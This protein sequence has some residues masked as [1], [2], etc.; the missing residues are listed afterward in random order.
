[1]ISEMVWWWDEANGPARTETV[2]LSK[3]RE[4]IPAFS[5]HWWENE[6][7]YHFLAFRWLDCELAIKKR[8]AVFLPLDWRHS[9][10]S[11]SFA[12]RAARLKRADAEG[13]FA[14]RP[15]SKTGGWQRGVPTSSHCTTCRSNKK[16]S[17]PSFLSLFPIC[18]SLSLL[19]L[20]LSS[21]SIV[22]LSHGSR[23]LRVSTIF[24]NFISAPVLF[25]LSLSILNLVLSLVLL[26]LLSLYDAS[27]FPR[28]FFLLFVVS[29]FLHLCLVSVPLPSH[30]C[31]F[32]ALCLEFFDASSFEKHS[33]LVLLRGPK[34]FAVESFA[35]CVWGDAWT[36]QQMQ[37]K[38]RGGV[39]VKSWEYREGKKC[40]WKARPFCWSA[41][42]VSDKRY[43]SLPC[44]M[45][46]AWH[47]LS[48]CRRWWKQLLYS[49]HQS[50]DGKRVQRPRVLM[51]QTLFT[52]K[53]K[54]LW[55]QPRRQAR[56]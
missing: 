26:S 13:G 47:A 48:Q 12:D 50:A 24:S 38:G 20:L 32:P 49:K 2:E 51:R 36:S 46:I 43:S 55:L 56:C 33:S 28:G 29:L 40:V 27:A 1:M 35:C 7:R 5:K 4:L 3:S 25:C 53:R 6:R 44:M 45:I 31:S 8:K 18:L 30:C 23:S 10:L 22:H 9:S 17:V 52:V 19:F 16:V 15:E 11:V 42:R 37:R 14:R 21:L 54:R 39:E 34:I 41:G